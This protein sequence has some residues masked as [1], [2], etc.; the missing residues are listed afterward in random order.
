VQTQHDLIAAEIRRWNIEEALPHPRVIDRAL[1]EYEEADVIVAP[2]RFVIETFLARGI[3][4]EKLKLVPWAAMPVV[5]TH[6][7]SPPPEQERPTILFVGGCSLR[8]GTPSLIESARALRGRANFRIVG[9]P[10]PRLFSRVGGLP[11]NVVAVGHVTGEQLASEFRGADI[12]VLPSIEDGS[13]L[14]TIEAMLAGLPVVVSDQAGAALITEGLS[15]FEFSAG[16]SAALTERLLVLVTD[17]DLRYRT[18]RAAKAAATTRTSETY[19]DELMRDVYEPL[20]TT[21]PQ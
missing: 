20:L 5:P 19:G 1:R 11:D 13:A 3:P 10:N 6:D 8:K 2:S 16:D 9:Q 7:P 18:G 21:S 14:V 12:F 15:G 4:E 17:P